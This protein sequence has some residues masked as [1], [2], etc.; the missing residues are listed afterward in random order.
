[1]IQWIRTDPH[2]DTAYEIS[3]NWEQTNASNYMQREGKR[4]GKSECLQISQKH[5][6]VLED[7]EA[8][9]LSS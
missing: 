2:Q 5:H 3:K 8:M 7:S 1:M 6:F 9:L 4:N